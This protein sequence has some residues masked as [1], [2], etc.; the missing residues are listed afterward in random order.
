M[1]MELICCEQTLLREVYEPKMTKKCLAMTYRL[2][3]ES[4]E[5]DI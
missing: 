1:K 4:S 3:M 5:K 2:A